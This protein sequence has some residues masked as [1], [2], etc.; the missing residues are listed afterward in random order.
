MTAE[1][2]RNGKRFVVRSDE[3]LTAYALLPNTRWDG[4]EDSLCITLP[5]Q[6]STSA[7]K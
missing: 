5:R 6:L 4:I 2:H 7:K 1:A 3:K